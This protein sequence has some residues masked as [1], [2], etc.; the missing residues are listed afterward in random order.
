MD[1]GRNEFEIAV[2]IVL[3]VLT[4]FVFPVIQGPYSVVNG[5]AT[6]FRAA[7]AATH[8]R[9]AIVQAALKFLAR[10]VVSPAA[11]AVW[12]ARSNAAVQ[13]SHSAEIS[14]VLRC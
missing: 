5:P 3:C 7:R 1:S 4:I 8:L 6:A 2:L 11:V 10:R 14:P 13:S 12:M 9:I